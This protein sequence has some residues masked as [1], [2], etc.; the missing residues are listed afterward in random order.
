MARVLGPAIASGL[1]SAAAF[2]WVAI[3]WL[4]PDCDA[5]GECVWDAACVGWLGGPLAVVLVAIAVVVPYRLVE[6]RWPRKA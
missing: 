1:V 3:G 4:C 6:G 5:V 2:W